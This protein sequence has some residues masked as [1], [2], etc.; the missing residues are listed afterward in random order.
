MSFD[1]VLDAQ[2]GLEALDDAR[3]QDRAAEV[4]QRRLFAERPGELRERRT[5]LVGTEVG[6]AGVRLGVGQQ[7]F[8]LEGGLVLGGSAA[9]A[10]R[11]LGYT[12]RSG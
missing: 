3:S 11:L 6:Q 1:P 12:G 9:H 5:E 10:R 4:V 2:A 7:R 8:V